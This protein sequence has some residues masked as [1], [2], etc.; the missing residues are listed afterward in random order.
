MKAI[1]LNHQKLQGGALI[2]VVLLSLVICTL[3]STYLVVNTQQHSFAER[4]YHQQLAQRNLQ[5]GLN[6]QLAYG[7]PFSTSKIALFDSEIDSFYAQSEPWGLFQL[8]HARATHASQS[9]S[10]SALLGQEIPK[11]F[12]FSLYLSDKGQSLS[13]LG[14]T[15]LQGKLSLPNGGVKKAFIGN[16]SFAG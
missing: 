6:L 4:L 8:I 7:D 9:A 12:D 2:Y 10:R 16:I 1:T 11:R 3:L 5:S 13:V 15:H 14:K